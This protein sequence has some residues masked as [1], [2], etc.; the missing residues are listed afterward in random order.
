VKNCAAIVVGGRDLDAVEAGRGHVGGRARVAVD[1]R[2]D[3]RLCG[4]ARLD[5]EASA[6]DRRSG[7]RRRARR[8]RDLLPPSVEELDE[9][10][11]PVR[12]YRLGDSG[13]PGGRLLPVAREGMRGQEPGGVDGRGL[14]DDQADAAPRPR[15]V[16]GEE[17]VGRQV[18]VDECGLVG[19][20][21][22]PVPELDGPQEQRAEER[23]KHVRARSARRLL[24][25]AGDGARRR[26]RARPWPARLALRP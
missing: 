17:V 23:V 10:P 4:G 24:G 5:V 8:G 19:G 9:E 12:P 15:L 3:V 18:I 16:V 13:E 14:E 26:R 21:D 6:R 1:D 22:D 11:R 20:R 25:A 2:L 7:D